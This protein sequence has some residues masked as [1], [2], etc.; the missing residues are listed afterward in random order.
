MKIYG[1]Q[2]RRCNFNDLVVDYNFNQVT[3]AD[4]KVVED[5]AITVRAIGASLKNAFSLQL[6][7][8]QVM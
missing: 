3:N 4:N 5:A 7:T 6:N 2:K 8:A 1:L